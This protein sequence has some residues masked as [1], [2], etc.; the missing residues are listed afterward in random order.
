MVKK[1]KLLLESLNHDTLNTE[2]NITEEYINLENKVKELEKK[3]F[4][5]HGP[6]SIIVINNEIKLSILMMSD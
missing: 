1:T 3:G 4:K 6:F 5:K 2:I